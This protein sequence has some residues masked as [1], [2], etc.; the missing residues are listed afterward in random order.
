MGVWSICPPQEIQTGESIWILCG[1]QRSVGEP[2]NSEQAVILSRCRQRPLFSLE[3]S[4]HTILNL[5]LW[6][7]LFWWE[8]GGKVNG[9]PI[10]TGVFP[11]PNYVLPVSMVQKLQGQT[12]SRISARQ[13]ANSFVN[14]RE[15]VGWMILCL[16]SI[17]A[18]TRSW[19]LLMKGHCQPG[20]CLKTVCL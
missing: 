8:N 12:N 7:V 14:L 20:R 13:L 11:V 19:G 16:G 9:G 10:L 6:P 3:S 18:T 1:S 15:H 4:G 2:V 17:D 5:V